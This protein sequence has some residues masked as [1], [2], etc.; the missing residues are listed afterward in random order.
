M[1]ACLLFLPSL[2]GPFSVDYAQ[3]SCLCLPASPFNYKMNSPSSVR[4]NLC[5]WYQELPKN[6][7]DI[8]KHDLKGMLFLCVLICSCISSA[9]AGCWPVD[10]CCNN[11][12]NTFKKD[13]IMQSVFHLKF[14]I[15]SIFQLY[16]NYM[17]KYHFVHLMLQAYCKDGFLFIVGRQWNLERK[18]IE[19]SCLL[20]M[21]VWR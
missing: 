2:V 15:R 1:L 7:S 19:T 6:K 9:V 8:K 13:L 17:H 10:W 18:I 21:F 3:L 11:S 20:P 4:V 5:N 16:E 12:G 14:R